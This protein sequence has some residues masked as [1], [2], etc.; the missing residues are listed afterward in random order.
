MHSLN[1][2][3]IGCGMMVHKYHI[4]NIIKDP[5]MKVVG[6]MDVRPEAAQ[7]AAEKSGA[8]YHTTDMDRILKDD[9]IQAVVIGTRQDSH[10][11]LAIEAAQ[12]GKHVFIEKPLAETNADAMHVQEA[13]YKAGVQLTCGWWFKQSPITKRVREVIAAPHFIHFTCRLPWLPNYIVDDEQGPFHYWGLLG[14]AGYNLHW[15]WHVMRS[16]PV[17]VYAMGYGRKATNTSTILI[18]FENGS[19]GESIFSDQGMGGILPKWYAEVQAGA[20]SA[21]MSGMTKLTFEGKDAPEGIPDNPYHTGF[22]EEFSRFAD[23]CLDGATNPMDAWE[24]SIP[25]LLTEKAVESMRSGLPV[26]VDVMKGFYLPNG[27]LPESIAR[28]G[29]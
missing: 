18:R 17:E 11:K 6:T 29:G 13:V 1:V 15:I 24:S 8:R 10:V 27:K 19:F 21:A 14:T 3:I 25:T 7:S 23:T 28:F 9:D 16:N 26:N 22:N 4:G 5:R 2:G 20:L 12:A